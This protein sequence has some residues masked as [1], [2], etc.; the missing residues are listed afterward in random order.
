MSYL[1]IFLITLIVFL[2]ACVWVGVSVFFYTSSENNVYPW[3]SSKVWLDKF[4]SCKNL[5]RTY[6]TMTSATP[7]SSRGSRH[8]HIIDGQSEN[9]TE[10]QYQLPYQ[11][12]A[13]QIS[14]R[15]HP[16]LSATLTLL[17]EARKKKG[18]KLSKT[19]SRESS[20]FP[21]RSTKPMI[22]YGARSK[23]S[24]TD[25]NLST[26]L[27]GHIT[28]HNRLCKTIIEVTVDGWGNQSVD[29]YENAGTPESHRQ[30]SLQVEFVIFCWL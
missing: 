6:Q 5:G 12:Q 17:V 21:T 30:R 10:E 18:W 14:C 3:N 16:P 28:R 26:P 9:D 19:N 1:Y 27:F 11:V 29:G 13:L 2:V 8:N 22:M 25:R 24:W 20:A 7:Q 15:I 23:V 4:Y